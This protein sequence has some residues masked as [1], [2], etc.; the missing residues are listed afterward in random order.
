MSCAV[1]LAPPPTEVVTVG[2]EV[3]LVSAPLTDTT[4]PPL[5]LAAAVAMPSPEGAAESARAPPTPSRRCVPAPTA[6][7]SMARW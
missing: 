6:V 1:T 7:M 3:A 4:P 2:V 5:P